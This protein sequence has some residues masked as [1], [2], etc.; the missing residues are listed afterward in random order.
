MISVETDLS[1]S[2]VSFYQPITSNAS[3]CVRACACVRARARARACVCVCLC[4]C[5]C[6]C[7][8]ELYSAVNLTLLS[9]QHFIRLID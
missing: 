2:F 1:F 6:V 8:H 4:V 9:E 3:A 5:V 7:G